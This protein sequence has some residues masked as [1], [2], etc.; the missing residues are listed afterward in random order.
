M[1]NACICIDIVVLPRLKHAKQNRITM[2]QVVQGSQKHAELLSMVEVPVA[3]TDEDTWGRSFEGCYLLPEASTYE[4]LPLQE[5]LACWTLDSRLP[6]LGGI[7]MTANYKCD[8]GN[9]MALPTARSGG[10]RVIGLSCGNCSQYWRL[11]YNP[12][13]LLATVS[14]WRCPTCNTGKSRCRDMFW[15]KD[16]CRN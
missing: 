1:Q 7:R 16:R 5:L 9:H 14:E 13:K 6:E 11:S 3:Q 2:R 15:N 10:A 12:N 4:E 8:C